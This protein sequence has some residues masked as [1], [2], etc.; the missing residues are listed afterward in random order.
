MVGSSLSFP[1]SFLGAWYQENRG[2]NS[3]SF[4]CVVEDSVGSL[5][6]GGEDF[7]LVKKLSGSND[8]ERLLR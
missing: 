4:C 7:F 2:M 3:S 8:A 6:S 1:L 5:E